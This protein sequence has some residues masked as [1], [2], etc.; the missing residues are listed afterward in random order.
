[1]GMQAFSAVR[2]SENFLGDLQSTFHCL[3]EPPVGFPQPDPA[4]I[5]AR[6]QCSFGTAVSLASE[7]VSRRKL[8][9]FCGFPPELAA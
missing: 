9:L 7:T 4:C 6:L 3:A 1:M 8:M 5:F 2:W